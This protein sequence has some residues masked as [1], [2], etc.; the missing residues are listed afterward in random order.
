MLTQNHRVTATGLLT[1]RTAPAAE[2]TRGQQS[3]PVAGLG[4]VPDR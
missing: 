3:T 1:T 4:A 2:G